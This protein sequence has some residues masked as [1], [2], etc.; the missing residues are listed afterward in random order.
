MPK[1][2]K[3]LLA[4]LIEDMHGA[5]M[6]TILMFQNHHTKRIDHANKM[7]RFLQNLVDV[8]K[9]SEKLLSD[10]EELK[11]TGFTIGT[12]YDKAILGVLQS[13]SDLSITEEQLSYIYNDE[14][15]EIA[16]EKFYIENYFS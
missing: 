15:D 1:I 6:S 4:D 14:Q 13:L 10:I 16:T 2:N 3:D 5:S 9:D 7:K 11:S 8:L 12:H